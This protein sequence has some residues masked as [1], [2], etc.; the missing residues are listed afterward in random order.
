MV[1]PN[2]IEKRSSTILRQN[3]KSSFRILVS[4]TAMWQ[5]PPPTNPVISVDVG[6]TSQERLHDVHVASGAGQR[7]GTLPLPCNCLWV[8]ALRGKDLIFSPMMYKLFKTV[9]D[10]FLTLSKRKS[11]VDFSPN[12]AAHIRGVKPRSSCLLSSEL[13]AKIKQN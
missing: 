4:G 11:T 5:T 3:I 13:S 6:S 10:F 7:Q 1:S 2:S 9:D 12:A 8:C